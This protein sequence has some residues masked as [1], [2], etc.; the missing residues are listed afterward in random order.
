[1]SLYLL[2]LNCLWYPLCL[3][4]LSIVKI[5]QLYCQPYE[6]IHWD[7][8]RHFVADMDNY[9]PVPLFMKFANNCLSI[10]ENWDIFN[11]FRNAVRKAGLRFCSEYMAAEDLQTNYID[12]GP[13]NKA[14]NMVSAF[15]GMLFVCLFESNGLNIRMSI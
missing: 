1:M 5:K 14:L 13:V 11:P 10:Y 6:S 15:H 3:Q 8:T 7:S 9:S 12:I 4:I 2:R